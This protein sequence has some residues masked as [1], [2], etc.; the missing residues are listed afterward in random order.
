MIMAHYR[1]PRPWLT[2]V[3]I[4]IG[5]VGIFLIAL[6][7][8]VPLSSDTAR[9]KVIEVLAARLDSEVQLDSLSLTVFPQLRAEG[10]GLTI[11]HKGRH[12][13]PPLISI[14]RFTVKGDLL[15]VVHKHVSTMT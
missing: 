12:D 1:I 3:L 11:R 5:T 4:G 9:T 15:D 7:S 6:L 13:V 2:A 8:V 10:R 14:R